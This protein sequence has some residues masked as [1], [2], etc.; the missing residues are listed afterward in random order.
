[1]I[2]TGKTG[3][4]GLLLLSVIGM[5]LITS[6]AMN[7]QPDLTRE[8]ARIDYELLLSLS[9]EPI[10]YESRVRPIL[11]QRCVVCHG[12][13]DA[14]CQLKLSSPEGIRR[15]ANPAKVYDGS[16]ITAAEPTRL[17]I[18]AHSTSDWRKK[19]FH[20]VLNEGVEDPESNL[21]NSVLYHMLRLKQRHPQPRVGMVPDSLNLE[22]DRPQTCPT[23]DNFS[24]YA[25]RHPLGGMPYAM[26]N[27]SED[28]YSTLVQWLAQGAPMPASPQPSESASKQITVWERFLNQTDNKHRL[29]ARYLFEHLFIAHIHF[30]GTDEREFYR[31]VRSRSGPGKPVNEIP[32]VRPYEDPGAGLF[33]YRFVRYHPS[34]VAKNHVVYPLGDE[35][36]KRYQSLFIEPDYTVAKLPGYQIE[37]AANPFKT[38]AD[39]PI[40]SR[41]RFL[42]D[43]ARFFI[44]GFI[45]GPVCRG[46]IALN[47]IEDQFWVMFI[48]PDKDMITYNEAFLDRMSDYLQLPA[49]QNGKL[50][51]L[52]IWTDYSKRQRKYMEARQT[53]F[54]HMK[55]LQ[56]EQALD[57]I[58]QGN[59]NPNAALTVFRHFDSA[60]VA[61]GLLGDYPETAWVIDYPLFER[62]HYL[63]VAGFDVF[64]NVGHQL[65][66]RL[67]MDFLR[68]EG[69]NLYLAFLPASHR[70]SIRDG[71]YRGIRSELSDQFNLPVEWLDVESVTG[72]QTDDPQREF[73]RK[74]EH[75]LSSSARSGEDLDR[76][77]SACSEQTPLDLEQRVD[78][79]MA[80]IAGMRGEHL[81]VFPDVSF[82]RVLTGDDS[83]DLAY[84][85]IRNK[86]YFN[87]TSM[88]SDATQRDAEERG[89]DTLTVVNW[90]EGS[91]PNFFF[92]VEMEEIENFAQAYQSILNRNDYER[93]V[94]LYGLR[95]TNPDFWEHADWFHEQYRREQPILSGLFDLNRYKNR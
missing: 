91:Y 64:G 50:D 48:D 79:A 36:M 92:V 27:L 26:P 1:M 49:A 47:V 69:E 25:N 18:D 39:L 16:R 68:M 10:P 76:C 75:R 81:I 55:T 13:Y 9:Q 11:E 43:D 77:G 54:E 6:C 95:R 34:I 56:L 93:F 94:A 72:Y 22:L 52:A 42:L 2:G 86:A 80:Q 88:L 40:R 73:Y 62:I 30:D 19:S 78:Q 14:P 59:G 37:T 24:D 38:F 5:A 20:P 41:Y 74:L 66:T 31:L 70:K 23:S 3:L 57:Y 12:C 28:E 15:G 58:W 8:Q 17:Y 60:S 33:Y 35:R 29:V 21:S 7:T 44:E 83:P 45:K 4:M 32:T 85:L 65:N 61:Y 67:Y 51:L 46:Q 89:A 53:H 90:L 82:I 71:W 63:L 87:V 84:T